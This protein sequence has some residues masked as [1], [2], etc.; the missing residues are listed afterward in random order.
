MSEAPV[1]ELA[2]AKV[3]HA[4]PVESG[5]ERTRRF[6]WPGG[7]SARLLLLTILF[8]SVAELLILAPS[9]ASFEEQWLTDRRTE[10]EAQA[11]RLENF[12]NGLQEQGE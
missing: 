5:I 9:M 2:V 4:D 6:F 11:D 8:V 1:T 12:L 7:L 10:W 3:P